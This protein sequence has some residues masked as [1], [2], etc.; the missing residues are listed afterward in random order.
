MRYTWTNND[1]PY[2]RQDKAVNGDKTAY[3]IQCYPGEWFAFCMDGDLVVKGDNTNQSKA[4][5]KKEAEDF[6]NGKT[7]YECWPD[8]K[9][10]LRT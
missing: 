4:E 7:E 6:L 3:L 10:D 2:L 9:P 8:P 5:A 1:Q